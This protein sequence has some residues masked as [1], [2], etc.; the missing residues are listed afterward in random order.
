MTF[1]RGSAAVAV[2]VAT[3]AAFHLAFLAVLSRID[4]S[5][6]LGP[7]L[8]F[9]LMVFVGTLVWAGFDAVRR[10]FV[11]GASCGP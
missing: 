9:F 1:T 10:G 2:R 8:L 3:L 5:D 6:P 11:T 7:G 4:T